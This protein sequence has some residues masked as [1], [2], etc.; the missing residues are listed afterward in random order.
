M[1]MFPL[2]AAL[3]CFASGAGLYGEQHDTV[4]LTSAHLVFKAHRDGKDA[5]TVMTVK[6]TNKKGIRV[7]DFD[8]TGVGIGNDD[9]KAVDLRS[10]THAFSADDALDGSLVLT[11]EPR[12]NDTFHFDLNVDLSF[13]DGTGLSYVFQEQT[14][15]ENPGNKLLI[16]SLAHP[17]GTN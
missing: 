3:V 8:L 4:T 13:S 9:T 11:F 5:D 10:S 15:S 16:L 1:Q 17:L 7:A 12:G 14:L 6:L 2:A